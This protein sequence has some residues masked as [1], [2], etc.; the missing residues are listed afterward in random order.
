MY[1]LFLLV[2][3][4]RE[5]WGTLPEARGNPRIAAAL[6]ALL[7]PDRS[8]GTECPDWEIA[9]ESW[10]WPFFS[11]YGEGLRAHAPLVSRCYTRN[12]DDEKG[13]SAHTLYGKTLQS[14]CSTFG[15]IQ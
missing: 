14:F 9:E 12:K 5:V 10:A 8:G 11:N 3:G 6:R 4:A 13:K 15:K 2:K 1:K 7:C